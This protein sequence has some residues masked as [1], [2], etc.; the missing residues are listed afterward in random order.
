MRKFSKNSFIS[1][2]IQNCEWISTTK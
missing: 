2:I 1:I